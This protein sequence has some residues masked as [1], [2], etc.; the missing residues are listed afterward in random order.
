[1]AGQRRR[2][3]IPGRHHIPAAHPGPAYGN[4]RNHDYNA[5]RERAES[6][7]ITIG[8]LSIKESPPP[9]EQC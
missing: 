9:P 4:A 1:M 2:Q 3:N 5:I 6:Y 8:D 7:R